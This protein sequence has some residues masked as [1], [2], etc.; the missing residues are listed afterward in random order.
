M[1]HTVFTLSLSALTRV[2]EAA[3]A[4]LAASFM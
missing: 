3:L 1:T 4:A 2:I